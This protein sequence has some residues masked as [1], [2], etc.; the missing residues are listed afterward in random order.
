M[1]AGRSPQEALVPYQPFVESLRQYFLN[2]PVSELRV[3]AREY[4]S[5]WRG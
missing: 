3:S 2:V 1:L 4:G 5:E